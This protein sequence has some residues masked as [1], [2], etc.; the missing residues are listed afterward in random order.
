MGDTEAAATYDQHGFRLEGA[1]AIAEYERWLV[2]HET[3]TLPKQRKN[4]AWLPNDD[5][6]QIKLAGA[7]TLFLPGR[8]PRMALPSA[9]TRHP[10]LASN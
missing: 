9:N 2:E 3:V 5:S 6:L 1:A 8:I 10:P 7:L 4:W